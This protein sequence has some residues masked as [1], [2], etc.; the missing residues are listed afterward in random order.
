M[1]VSIIGVDYAGKT[2]QVLKLEE[3]LKARGL[4]VKTVALEHKPTFENV[5]KLSQSR[6]KNP[7][8]FPFGLDSNY[9]SFALNCDFFNHYFKNIMPLLKQEIDII[10]SDRYTYCYQAYAFAVKATCGFTHTFF[11]NLFYKPD[12]QICLDLSYKEIKNRVMAR[13]EIAMDETESILK[14]LIKFYRM[15]CI[16]DPSIVLIDASEEVGIVTSK[17]IKEIDLILSKDD[18]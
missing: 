3:I 14:R 15:I 4:S 8:D 12:L 6:C 2:T 13:N 5:L 7:T 17:I 18:L 16:K 1:L 11:E 9:Y 10:I